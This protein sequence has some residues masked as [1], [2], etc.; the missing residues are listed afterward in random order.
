MTLK[1]ET[2]AEEELEELNKLIRWLEE[3]RPRGWE[4]RVRGLVRRTHRLHGI[5][6]A[7]QEP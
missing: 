7:H 2:E 4:K 3:N 6:G 1:A 5:I